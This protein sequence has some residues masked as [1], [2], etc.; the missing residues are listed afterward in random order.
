MKIALVST[1]NLPVP[2]VRGG[3]VE[4]LTTHIINENEK[5]KKFEIDLYT[6]YD[7]KIDINQ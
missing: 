6:I 2:A 7:S 3:A 5:Q 4:E 1:M